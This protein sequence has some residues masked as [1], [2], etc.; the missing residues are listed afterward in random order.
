M[1]IEDGKG[2]GYSSFVNSSNRLGVEATI[3]SRSHHINHVQQQYYTLRINATATAADDCI[4]YMKNNDP[5]DMLID[6]FYLYSTTATILTVKV[7]D[8]GTPASPT[9]IVPTNCNAGSGNV[10]DGFFYQGVELDAGGV[11][12]GGNIV[13]THD[14][15]G[16]TFGK[17]LILPFTLI[18]PKN[19]VA[20]F[21]TNQNSTPTFIEVGFGYH[22]KID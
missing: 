11:L 4:G 5:V 19:K 3:N 8:L 18:L 10:A 21:Y 7:G 16:T 14:V 20:T 22:P 17:C 13:I 9:A 6:C 12:S 2:R 1:L 15:D